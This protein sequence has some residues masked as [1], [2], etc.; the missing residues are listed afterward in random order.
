LAAFQKQLLSIAGNSES[1][2]HSPLEPSDSSVRDCVDAAIAARR[3]F[4]ASS[5]WEGI[6]SYIV[7]GLAQDARG[8]LFLVVGDS[9][10]NGGGARRAEPSVSTY[11]CSARVNAPSSDFMGRCGD[12]VEL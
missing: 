7:V 3:P 5:D 4:Y 2:G 11:R 9:D 12:R 8:H 10:V 6:D 1:C